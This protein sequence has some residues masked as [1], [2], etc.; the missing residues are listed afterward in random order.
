MGR[1]L[2]FRALLSNHPLLLGRIVLTS[3]TVMLAYSY[4][5]IIIGHNVSAPP[6]FVGL[7][8]GILFGTLTFYIVDGT[9]FR[10]LVFGL[11]GLIA[12]LT[13][14]IDVSGQFVVLDGS[15]HWLGAVGMMAVVGVILPKISAKNE[16]MTGILYFFVGLSCVAVAAIGLFLAWAVG[17]EALGGIEPAGLGLV[18]TG[19]LIVW[20]NGLRMWAEAASAVPRW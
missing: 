7:S 8:T 19:G 3:A 10:R 1:T 4:A 15:A 12:S 9:K 18:L 2:R 14:V 20:V 11:L 17:D 16:P 13:I 6:S 5:T